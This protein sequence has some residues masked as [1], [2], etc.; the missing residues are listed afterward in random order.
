MGYVPFYFL[1][2]SLFAFSLR[3][4]SLFLS[5]AIVSV[6]PAIPAMPAVPRSQEERPPHASLL[7]T[8]VMAAAWQSRT[9]GG[10]RFGVSC[11]HS[12]YMIGG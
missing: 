5:R 1:N 3:I 10:V 7:R 12:P 2:F 9:K 6:K 4:C 11:H 8:S